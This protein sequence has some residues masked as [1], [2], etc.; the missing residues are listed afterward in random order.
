MNIKKIFRV[1]IIFLIIIFAYCSHA[2][3]KNLILK[4]A[5]DTILLNEKNDNNINTEKIDKNLLDIKEM[6]QLEIKMGNPSAFIDIYLFLK[7]IVKDD[8]YSLQSLL[9]QSETQELPSY[10]TK[11]INYSVAKKLALALKENRISIK[12][13]IIIKKFREKN[14]CELYVNGNLLKN[15]FSFYSP[16]GIPIYVGLYCDDNTFEIQ[17]IRPGESQES[18]HVLFNHFV[19]RQNIPVSLPNP[20]T[21]K[22]VNVS[23]KEKLNETNKFDSLNENSKNFEMEKNDFQFVTGLGFLKDFGALSNANVRNIKF[24]KG[25]ILYSRSYIRSKYFLISFDY[26]NVILKEK[27]QIIF[28]DPH[29]KSETKMDGIVNSNGYF[30]RPGMGICVPFFYLTEKSKIES[31]FLANVTFLKGEYASSHK[32]G[33]GVQS[34]IG[35][36]FEL[37]SGF[38]FDFKLGV[39]YSFGK[40]NGFQLGMQTQFGYSF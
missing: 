25:A 15:S 37:G 12:T 3:D 26:S 36:S 40:L 23:F 34:A 22:K 10:I 6:T 1:F 33:Y 31:D 16:A 20:N 39:G 27:L 32:I 29:S 30:I 17:K 21:V 13:K 38:I 14:N 35:P 24:S 4:I 28:I 19:E 8:I 2:I 5:E 11:L 18:Q 7:G 9:F